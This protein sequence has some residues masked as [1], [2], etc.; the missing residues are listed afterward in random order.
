MPVQLTL[1]STRDGTA[2]VAL[3]PGGPGVADRRAA[4]VVRNPAINAE[5]QRLGARDIPEI[6]QRY[7]DAAQPEEIRAACG[8]LIDII[9]TAVQDGRARRR[10][11]MTA[12]ADHMTIPS[13]VARTWFPLQVDQFLA[14]SPSDQMRFVRTCGMTALAALVDAGQDILG[15]NDDEWA[16]VR[17]RATALFY[18]ERAGIAARHPAQPSLDGDLFAV[19]PDNAAVEAAAQE[20]LDGARATAAEIDAD[21]DSLRRVID[22]IAVMTGMKPADVLAQALGAA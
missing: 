8:P 13:T 10:Q 22:V 19:G 14:A 3:I 17:D 11:Y 5:L 7:S 9:G 4:A 2:V 1:N 12:M 21:E 20:A 18:A 6:V 15:L 16:I